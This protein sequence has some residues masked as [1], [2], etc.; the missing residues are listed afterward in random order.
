[1]CNIILSVK[2]KLFFTSKRNKQNSFHK[3]IFM[4]NS[5]LNSAKKTA[6]NNNA[7]IVAINIDS[8][9]KRLSNI[10]GVNQKTKDSIYVYP[11]DFTAIDISSKKGKSFRV[12]R[13]GQFETIVNAFL[14]IKKQKELKQISNET[15]AKSAK[16]I[17][18]LFADIYKEYYRVNDYSFQSVSQSNNEDKKAEILSFLS[19]CKNEIASP[20]KAEKKK[21]N[22][23]P[24]NK[25]K[26]VKIAKETPVIAEIKTA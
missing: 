20:V 24:A 7:K 25:K 9:A 1:M 6:T 2:T 3:F 11:N 19:F 4:Q 18:E 21:S 5:K 23:I 14:Q 8:V 12:K 10:V 15:F 17:T 26:S 22:T 13:R 16:E